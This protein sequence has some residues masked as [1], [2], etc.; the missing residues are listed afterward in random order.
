MSGGV[1]IAPRIV[2]VQPTQRR[3]LL[4]R[5]WLKSNARPMPNTNRVAAMVW[6]SLVDNVACLMGGHG[7][8][9]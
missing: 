7:E 1:L 6:S 2:S 5:Q 3:W 8:I 4:L 9:Q